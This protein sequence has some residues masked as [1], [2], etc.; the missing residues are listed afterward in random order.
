M[1]RE[2]SNCQYWRFVRGVTGDPI[3]LGT[4]H[5]NPPTVG[6]LTRVG[7]S[8][9]FPETRSVDFCGHHFSGH[10]LRATRNP[11]IPNRDHELEWIERRDQKERDY[12]V[13]MMTG[14]EELWLGG[15]MGIA[16]PRLGILLPIQEGD[17]SPMEITNRLGILLDESVGLTERDAWTLWDLLSNSTDRC[18]V[19]HLRSLRWFDCVP[20]EHYG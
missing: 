11:T 19:V 9:R 12:F 1:K 4:C 7:E 8:D 15:A 17:I 18:F 2:C 10:L 14:D 5:L 16:R 13:V 20:S 3:E 6:T